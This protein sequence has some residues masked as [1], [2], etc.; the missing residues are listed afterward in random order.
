MSKRYKF[1]QGE[2]TQTEIQQQ[3]AK[4]LDTRFEN[5]SRKIELL[6]VGQVAVPF[7]LLL[8]M[9]FRGW[10]R[11]LSLTPMLIPIILNAVWA[12]YIVLAHRLTLAHTTQQPIPNKEHFLS[13]YNSMWLRFWEGGLGLLVSTAFLWGAME[14]WMAKGF[15][16]SLVPIILLSSFCVVL[17]FVYIQHDWVTKVVI[18]GPA[19][20]PRVWK[21]IAI[22]FVLLVGLPLLSGFG[23]MMQVSIGREE[24]IKLLIWPFII[25]LWIFAVGTAIL[26]IFAILIGQAQY[27]QWR[28]LLDS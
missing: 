1:K 16:D 23:R 22:F 11:G 19:M 15:A 21:L 28:D 14:L 3:L 12:I 5:R 18:E 10:G 2:L 13:L 20:Y 25:I 27:R 26:G 6:L 17:V 7:A 4:R 24:T 9:M 8:A